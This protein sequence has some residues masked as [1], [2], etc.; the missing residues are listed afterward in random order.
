MVGKTSP[1]KPADKERFDII[2]KHCGCLP[3]IISGM[4]YVPCT[5]EHVTSRGRRLAD[6]HQATIGLCEWHHFATLGPG[7]TRQGMSG[8]LGPS[9][10]WG[11]KNFEDHFGDEVT[12]LIPCQNYLISLFE[13]QPWLEYDLPRATARQLRI[14]WT[15]IYHASISQS[16]ERD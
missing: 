15:T 1:I 10:A 3:C 16:P 12:V 2:A 6:E 7:Q 4:G 8:T 5:I 13:A 9:L 14:E 11:R